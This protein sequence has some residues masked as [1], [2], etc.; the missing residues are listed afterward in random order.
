MLSLSRGGPTIWM[1]TKDAEKIGVTDN[2]WIETVN[3][4]GV[5][6][7]R[8][9]VSHRMPEGT[10]Y[11]HHAQDRL[12][13]VPR[14]ETTGRLP[15]PLR[16]PGPLAGRLGTE[17]AGTHPRR[18]SHLPDH[19]QGHEDLLVGELGRRPRQLRCDR[20]EGRTSA[21]GLGQD[22]ARVR[23]DLHVLPAAVHMIP[24][25]NRLPHPPPH[26]LSEPRHPARCSPSPPRLGA[27]G[28]TNA[29]QAFPRRLVTSAPVRD[30]VPL[31]HFPHPLVAGEV[32][33]QRR[34]VDALHEDGP[35]TGPHSD[36]D[37]YQQPDQ[38][39]HGRVSFGSCARTPFRPPVG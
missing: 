30:R 20:R 18:P 1:S 2:D 8:A 14:T 6:A 39:S 22:Q 32:T 4:K 10:V 19:G 12:I 16:R 36:D 13:D 9:I 5:V 28:L 34:P 23:A 37:R 38:C 11:M 21:R 17:Q 25:P 15:T 35:D 26:R 31:Q 7:A 24:A 3:R 33:P 27:R 29:V